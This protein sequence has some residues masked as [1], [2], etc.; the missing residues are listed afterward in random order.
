[1]LI[2]DGVKT[3]SKVSKIRQSA[4]TRQST[5]AIHAHPSVSIGFVPLADAAPLI[6]AFEFGYFR[7]EGL[8][9]RL[10]RQLGWGSVFAGLAYGQ[11]DVA[12]APF[13]MLFALAELAREGAQQIITRW[14]I[15]RNGNA[16][17]LSNRLKLR[18][19]SDAA[20]FAALARSMRPVP[21]S[22]GVVSRHSMHSLVL[23]LWLRQIGLD[24]DRHARFVCLPPGQMIGAMEEQ[25][26]DGFCAGEPWNSL[27]VDRGKGWIAASSAEVLPD[28]VEKVLAVSRTFDMRRPGEHAA[29]L[30][31]LARAARDCQVPDG[32]S[33]I[34]RLLA[35][36]EYL[37]L[38]ARILSECL[39]LGHQAAHPARLLF[40][41]PDINAASRQECV[42]IAELWAAEGLG[43]SAANL[44]ALCRDL[45]LP[46]FPSKAT[47][48]KA[49]N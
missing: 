45:F 41:G 17:T 28:H 31:A 35:R 5:Q 30:R 4:T 46:P 34:A 1:M 12:H 42:R 48:K 39:R 2:V 13:P 16:I 32:R 11:L 47:S 44:K 38:D 29:L 3:K 27:A 9:V 23:R 21:V 25:Y 7:S 15:N 37:N 49:A 22:F 33:E 36:R 20:T 26:I 19:A 24:P 8:E 14:V 43:S 6:V 18:G 10:E 40:H